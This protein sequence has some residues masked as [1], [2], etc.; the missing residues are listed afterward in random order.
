MEQIPR[1]KFM[2]KWLSILFLICYAFQGQLFAEEEAITLIPDGKGNLEI[3][4]NPYPLDNEE[5][6]RELP[7]TDYQ[8]ALIKMFVVLILL[9]GMIGLTIWLIKRFMRTRSEVQ[10]RSNQ[11]QII[12][13]RVLSPKSML[14][15]IEVENQKILISESHLEVRPIEKIADDQDEL[16]DLDPDFL[17]AESSKL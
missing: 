2:R 9:I 5:F 10:N 1:I 3:Q 15:L 8:S 17:L 16:S 13:K 14:Y 7:A 11:I 12:E 6:Y 4:G